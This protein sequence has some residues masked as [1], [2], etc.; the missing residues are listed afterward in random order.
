MCPCGTSKGNSEKFEYVKSIT[1]PSSK[2]GEFGWE[3]AR[4]KTKN[5]GYSCTHCGAVLNKLS[6]KTG[7]LANHSESP[8]SSRKSKDGFDS[9]WERE[10]WLILQAEQQAGTWESV[11]HHSIRLRIADC[12]TKSKTGKRT[13]SFYTPDFFAVASQH[14]AKFVGMQA[15][16]F[17]V[18]GFM[19]EAARV[20]LNVAA[21]KHPWA[22]F[23]ICRKTKQ[24]WTR[25]MVTRS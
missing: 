25:E 17:E 12:G 10:F 18:K 16:F 6:G 4:C 9:K 7:T 19:R 22:K 2:T 11:N 13:G 20:R 5:F 21:D 23:W 1:Q 15:A 14:T 3:C 8:K 24:G